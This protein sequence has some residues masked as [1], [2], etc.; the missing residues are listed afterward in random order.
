M[1]DML[2]VPSKLSEICGLWML[3]GEDASLGCSYYSYHGGNINL[4]RS[5]HTEMITVI[6]PLS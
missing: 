5:D 2:R 6:R 1:L 3:F 4:P